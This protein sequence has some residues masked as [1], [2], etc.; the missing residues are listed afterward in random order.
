MAEKRIR[1]H[2]GLDILGDNPDVK[3]LILETLASDPNLFNIGRI[4]KA[5]N[6]LGIHYG[7]TDSESGNNVLRIIAHDGDLLK[8]W[9]AINKKDNSSDTYLDVINSTTNDLC[10][11]QPVYI[12]DYS[13]DVYRVDVGN[14]I[15]IN[16]KKIVGLVSDNVIESNGGSGKILVS[17][18][19]KST[20]LNWDLVTGLNGG[21]L[22]R[23]RYFL[24]TN[25]GQLSVSSPAEE[26]QYMCSIG[27]SLNSTDFLIKIERPITI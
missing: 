19:L 8:L 18:I 7:D 3:N 25:N 6:G 23:T 16:K 1:V 17:G 15:D 24:S 4:W 5:P 20:E 27:E 9:T 12:T 21:L 22:P 26:G 10:I 14:A 11:G 2:G 13:Q